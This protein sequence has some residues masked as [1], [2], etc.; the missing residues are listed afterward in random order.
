MKQA[1]TRFVLG[2]TIGLAAAYAALYAPLPRID[3]WV[4]ATSFFLTI[5]IIVGYAGQRM[6]LSPFK[7]WLAPAPADWK[8]A[9]G[10]FA[11]MAAVLTLSILV[12]SYL[13]P[14]LETVEWPML[15][16]RSLPLWFWRG[17]FLVCW[18]VGLAIAFGEK[19]ARRS[20]TI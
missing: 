2:L 17:F 7:K 1:I 4:E 9:I 5:I 18:L 13:Y 16:G 19:I 6:L 10:G 11:M 14:S 15:N 12:S 20:S 8:L 3:S